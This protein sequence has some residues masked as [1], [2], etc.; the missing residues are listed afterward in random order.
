MI[1]DN[2]NNNN[3]ES[4]TFEDKFDEKF[5]AFKKSLNARNGDKR[6]NMACKEIFL[7]FVTDKKIM[8]FGRAYK[9]AIRSLYEECIEKFCEQVEGENSKIN[10][11]TKIEKC[12]SRI[13]CWIKYAPTLKF[14]ALKD[15]KDNNTEPSQWKV[16]IEN[17]KH[18]RAVFQYHNPPNSNVNSKNGINA[19]PEKVQT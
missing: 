11:C 1:D 14:Q 9:Q 15:N 13:K 17:G 19:K 12:K 4:Q 2:K 16:C 3:R 18:S 7:S 5:E 8:Y 10:K 6:Q